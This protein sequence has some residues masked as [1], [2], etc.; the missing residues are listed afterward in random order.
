VMDP[1][2]RFAMTL[3][4]RLA[5]RASGLAH[6]AATL[7]SA[8]SP[9]TFTPCVR[10]AAT[11]AHSDSDRSMS[12]VAGTAHNPLRRRSTPTVSGGANAGS[13]PRRRQLSTGTAGGAVGAGTLYFDTHAAAKTLAASGLTP[14]QVDAVVDVTRSAMIANAKIDAERLAAARA[15]FVSRVAFAEGK[16]ELELQINNKTAHVRDELK[17]I[18]AIDINALRA[19]ATAADKQLT[20]RMDGV[21]KELA[22]VNER[23]NIGREVLEKKW[24][25]ELEKLEN[26]LIKFAIGFA[27]T[28]ALVSLGAIRVASMLFGG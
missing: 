15:E 4:G 14:E 28:T 18:E 21:L 26:R 12:M 1:I 25:G 24:L 10:T 17:G 9:T 22:L 7:P 20:R 16:G 3:L 23:R 19:D 11:L 6:H 2:L 8:R 27:G 5:R 13:A